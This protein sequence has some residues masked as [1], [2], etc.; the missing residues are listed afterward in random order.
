M[1]K[2]STRIVTTVLVVLLIAMMVLIYSLP[3]ISY[4]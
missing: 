2:K 4:F 3:G 1:T